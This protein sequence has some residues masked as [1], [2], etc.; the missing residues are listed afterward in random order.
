MKFS[1]E[2]NVVKSSGE[3]ENGCT[4]KHCSARVVI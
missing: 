2:H 4:P 1:F 3:I